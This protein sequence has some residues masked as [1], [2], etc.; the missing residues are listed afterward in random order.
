M[1]DPTSGSQ[2]RKAWIVGVFAMVA[3]LACATAQSP[4]DSG[5]SASTG[6]SSSDF[7]GESAVRQEL[8]RVDVDRDG[9]QTIITLVGLE[10]PIHSVTHNEEDNLLI[11]EL[12][13]VKQTSKS[14]FAAL[15][16][17]SSQVSVYDGPRGPGDDF[18]SRG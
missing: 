12:P 13:N 1:V 5:E 4:D 11:I 3:M 18:D 7:A 14:L 17:T 2:S 6:G 16:D 8:S 15:T 9:E 10:D